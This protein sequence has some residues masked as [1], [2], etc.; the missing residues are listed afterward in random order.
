MSGS[1]NFLYDD[2]AA[3]SDESSA[4]K[5][6]TSFSIDCISA[7]LYSSLLHKYD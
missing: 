7:M 5:Y 4:V 1:V 6:G 3:A 2:F